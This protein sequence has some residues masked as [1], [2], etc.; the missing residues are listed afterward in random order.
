MK[1]FRLVSEKLRGSLSWRSLLAV[2]VAALAGVAFGRNVLGTVYVV[3]GPSMAPNYDSGACLLTVPVYTQLKRSDVVLV[4]DGH[5][6]YAVK[7]IIGLPGETVRISHGQVFIYR[8]RLLEPYL[9]KNTYTFPLYGHKV[10]ETLT[11]KEGQYAVM[12][13]NRSCSVDSRSYG[14]V[15]ESQI[16]RRVPLP[17]GFV[18]ADLDYSIRPL[19]EGRAVAK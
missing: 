10:S 12:G 15:D 6:S 13:D 4:D 9:P 14:P 18:R 3:S 11:L 1:Q 2:T 5:N 7:R 16:L 8:Q 19:P 17:E